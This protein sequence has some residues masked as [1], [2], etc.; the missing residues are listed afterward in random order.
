MKRT[1]AVRIR[2]TPEE[3]V[4]ISAAGEAV[5]L[6]LCSFARMAAVKA[7]GRKPAKPPRKKP[8]HHQRTLAQ[9]TEQLGR[10][11]NNLHQ[12]AR[13]LNGGGSCEPSVLTEIRTELQALREAVLAYNSAAEQ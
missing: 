5:G 11:G 2:L 10:I 8:D 3:R 1:D 13:V 12:C 7:A 4:A 9:W 6:G